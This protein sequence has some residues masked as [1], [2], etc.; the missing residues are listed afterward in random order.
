[1]HDATELLTAL[2]RGDP[3]AASRLLPRAYDA[4]RRPAAQRLEREQPGQ[5]LLPTGFVAIEPHAVGQRPGQWLA[6]QAS[7]GSG[8]A[9]SSTRYCGRPVRSDSVARCASI[10]RLW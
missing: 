6:T 5:T 4:L 7:S 3:H 1:M 9:P 2:G 8:L 10:P